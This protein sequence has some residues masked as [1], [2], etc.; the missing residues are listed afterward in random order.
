MMV[1][2]AVLAAMGMAMLKPSAAR[3]LLIGTFLAVSLAGATV[4]GIL[5][6]PM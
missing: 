2:S 5:L 3:R 1:G 4:F 6:L